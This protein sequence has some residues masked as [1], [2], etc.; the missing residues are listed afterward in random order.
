[1]PAWKKRLAGRL[2]R[3]LAGR[4]ARTAAA[5]ATGGM[6]E[7]AIAVARQA[8]GPQER[9]MDHTQA[10]LI[11]LDDE[12]VQQ[13]LADLVIEIVEAA[14]D[15]PA[16]Q[17][18][19]M[20]RFDVQSRPL[21]VAPAVL[22][23]PFRKRVEEHEG[24]KLVVYLD[25]KG[26]PH[27][28]IGHNC[29][30]DSIP[31]EQQQVGMPISEELC[32]ELFEDD[33]SDAEHRAR[34]VCSQMGLEF[35]GLPPP[36]REALHEMH[37]QLGSTKWRGMFSRLK[38]GNWAEAAREALRSGLVPGKPSKW[39]LD[40]PQR[41]LNVCHFLSRQ[42]LLFEVGPETTFADGTRGPT[43]VEHRWAG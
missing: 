32:A 28:G 21:P 35:I 13:K 38:S 3:R 16:P 22:S 25:S 31:D 42:E 36:V 39:F 2:A 7:E 37:F 20:E 33:L 8:R 34:R 14:G 30:T 18:G 11:A 29:S 23:L 6:S 27:C 24:K 17:P 43:V 41:S 26:I 19:G 4:L 15:P 5:A 9:V 12:R 40:T 1:M 10:V